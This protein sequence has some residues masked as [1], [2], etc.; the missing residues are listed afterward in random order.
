VPFDEKDDAKAAGARWD[1]DEKKW[2]VVEHASSFAAFERWLPL[3][4]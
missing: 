2:Y 4:E 3:V 1:G